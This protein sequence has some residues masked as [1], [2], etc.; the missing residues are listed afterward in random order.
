M[1]LF[2]PEDENIHEQENVGSS[3][4]GQIIPLI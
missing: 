1:L 4:Q 2:L 3:L